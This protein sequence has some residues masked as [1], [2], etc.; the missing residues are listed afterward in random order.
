[1]ALSSDEFEEALN[2]TDSVQFG[3]VQVLVADRYRG[4]RAALIRIPLSDVADIPP[5]NIPHVI[6]MS[7]PL[8]RLIENNVERLIGMEISSVN[9]GWIS[10]DDN[11][12]ALYLIISNDDREEIRNISG[13]DIE[14]IDPNSN[15]K[16]IK[17][18][19]KRIMY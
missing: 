5:N 13:S 6:E 1:M 9:K 7:D 18:I 16:L 8:E 17:R 19:E 10:E 14:Y 2:D 11:G 4:E 15:A 3:D 12:I